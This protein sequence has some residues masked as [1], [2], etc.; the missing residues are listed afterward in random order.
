MLV[1]HDDST[2][3]TLPPGPIQWPTFKSLLTQLDNRRKIR[4]QPHLS[5]DSTTV[6]PD[7][8][9]DIK[10]YDYIPDFG[11]SN[12]GELEIFKSTA[13]GRLLLAHPS[14]SVLDILDKLM[15]PAKNGFTLVNTL[16][17]L[18]LREYPQSREMWTS[19][20]C[21]LIAVEKYGAIRRHILS[22]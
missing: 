16:K 14:K 11:G 12:M 22:I 15:S 10:D 8:S 18:K 19:D 4:V 17:Q 13:L 21:L 1:Y 6:N 2:L 9:D 20:N 7:S 5:N 3:S